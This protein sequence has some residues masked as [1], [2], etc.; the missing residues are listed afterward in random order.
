[1]ATEGS[2][3]FHL[4]F[5]ESPKLADHLKE[6]KVGEKCTISVTFQ[7]DSVTDTGIDGTIEKLEPKGYSEDEKSDKE[8]SE[9]D[10]PES[11]SPMPD[12]VTLRPSL[13]MTA[14][15]STGYGS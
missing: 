10:E 3:N 6:K 1:M 4:D 12:E 15:V 9:T 5:A 13:Y 11:G 7:V 2:S 8:K 14:A